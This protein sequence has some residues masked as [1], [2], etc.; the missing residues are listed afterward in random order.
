MGKN[1]SPTQV[2]TNFKKRNLQKVQQAK[3]CERFMPLNPEVKIMHPGNLERG[4][5][6]KWQRR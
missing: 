1:R 4:N 5:Q 2:C 3:F 6:E